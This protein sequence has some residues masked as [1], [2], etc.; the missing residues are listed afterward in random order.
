[1]DGDNRNPSIELPNMADSDSSNANT[2]LSA[3]NTNVAD[4]PEFHAPPE[5]KH[6]EVD[7][8]IQGDGID[9]AR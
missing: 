5:L 4:A 1:M 2:T 9:D 8:N 3:G 7:L 6:V